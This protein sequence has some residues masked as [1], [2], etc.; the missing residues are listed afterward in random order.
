M[1]QRIVSTEKALEDLAEYAASQADGSLNEKS[2]DEKKIDSKLSDI[3]ADEDSLFSVMKVS[4]PIFPEH[5]SYLLR[6]V[7]F[8]NNFYEVCVRNLSDIEKTFLD[9]EKYVTFAQGNE[10]IPA[11]APFYYSVFRTLW[12]NR[13]GEYSGTIDDMRRSLKNTFEETDIVTTSRTHISE[14][15]LRKDELLNHVDRISGS[16]IQGWIGTEFRGEDL[17]LYPLKNSD[18]ILAKNFSRNMFYTNDETE[19]VGEVFHWLTDKPV[20]VFRHSYLKSKEDREKPIFI[21]FASRKQQSRETGEFKDCFIINVTPF[22][23]D[24]IRYSSI[25]VIIE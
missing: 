2:V 19:N 4:D 13:V 10:L 14:V 16:K 3:S 25:G 11:S 12:Q 15:S 6:G 1:D 24:V 8:F 21:S 5:I 17:Q 7:P 23:D 9:W 22:V 18:I 20:R